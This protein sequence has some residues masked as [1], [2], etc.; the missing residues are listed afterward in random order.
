MSKLAL[1]A[2]GLAS[3][4][5]VLA[6]W[7]KPART[8]VTQLDAPLAERAAEDVDEVLSS[9]HHLVAHAP[10]SASATSPTP[11]RRGEASATPIERA[12]AAPGSL[13]VFVVDANDEPMVVR[14]ATVRVAWAGGGRRGRTGADVPTAQSRTLR[15]TDRASFGALVP[16]TWSV[17]CDVDAWRSVVPAEVR[18]QPGARAEVRLRIERKRRITVH[19]VD[20]AGHPAMLDHAHD[21]PPLGEPF[22]LRLTRAPTVLGATFVE[23]ASPLSHAC[24]PFPGSRSSGFFVDAPEARSAWLALLHGDRVVAG[25][26]APCGDSEVLLSVATGELEHGFGEIALCVVDSRTGEPLPN[27]RVLWTAHGLRAREIPLDERGRGTLS[28]VPMVPATV[29]FAADGYFVERAPVR[30]ARGESRDLG[31]VRLVASGTIAG[32]LFE[33]AAIFVSVRAW[34]LGDGE[35][36]LAGEARVEA[37]GTFLLEDVKPGEYLV[38]AKSGH[39]PSLHEVRRGERRDSALVVV[40]GGAR[41]NVTLHGPISVT[42][43]GAK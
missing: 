4:L 25:A 23:E 43:D 29:Q 6:A 8:S 21:G 39:A 31:R 28:R 11:P 7:V 41:A 32:R 10:A 35:P 34:N 38:T 42:P 1:A 9:T 26:P 3:V 40:A 17:A 15:L 5:V 33:P 13:D 27:A 24:T 22:T 36:E 16:G 14:D 19:V 18:V 30:L 20:E 12:N 37:D 2:L